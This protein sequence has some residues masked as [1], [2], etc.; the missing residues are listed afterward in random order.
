MTTLLRSLRP[1]VA[2]A[3]RLVLTTPNPTGLPVVLLEWVRSHRRFYTEELPARVE[4]VPLA[5]DA[6]FQ[7]TFVDCLGFSTGA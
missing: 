7:D 3:G 4:H 5:S 6:A 2:P 1:L